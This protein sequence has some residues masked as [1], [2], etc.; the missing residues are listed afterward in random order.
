MTVSSELR[1]HCV[2]CSVTARELYRIAHLV[3]RCPGSPR[4]ASLQEPRFARA[5]ERC[6]AVDQFSNS[7]SRECLQKVPGMWE[8][9]ELPQSLSS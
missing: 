9:R 6:Y 8:V 2:Y 3:Q 7:T 5:A 1:M 4:R